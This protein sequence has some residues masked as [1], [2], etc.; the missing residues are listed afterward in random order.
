[1]TY[2]FETSHSQKQAGF[3]L[4]EVL[5]VLLLSGVIV[6]SLTVLTGQWLRNWNRSSH[7]IEQ[8]EFVSIALD[9]LTE[10]LQT[11][12]PLTTNGTTPYASLRGTSRGLRF[13]HPAV[14]QA[15]SAGLEAVEITQRNGQGVLRSRSAI[16]ERRPI[17]DLAMA[18]S[19]QLLSEALRLDIEYLAENGPWQADWTLVRLPRAI[20]IK[21]SIEGSP[22]PMLSQVVG[23]HISTPAICAR[24]TSISTCES[25]ASGDRI[26]LPILDRT[27]PR[28]RSRD[29]SGADE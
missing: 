22:N 17:E 3:S 19:V 14:G 8:V 23:L 11:A 16:D 28:L 20:R 12:I 10:D 26:G 4:L 15:A 18:D 7:A 6:S 13:I 27:N 2:E 5:C 21:L 29:R 24:A 1:M 25:L 9:R